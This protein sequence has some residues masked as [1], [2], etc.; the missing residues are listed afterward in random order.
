MESNEH[1]SPVKRT[2][3][4]EIRH[5]KNKGKLQEDLNAHYEKRMGG[6]DKSLTDQR[7]LSNTISEDV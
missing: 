3:I 6:F 1:V 7:L 2:A 5:L 4:E